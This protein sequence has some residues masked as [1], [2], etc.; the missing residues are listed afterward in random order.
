M[1]SQFVKKTRRKSSLALRLRGDLCFFAKAFSLFFSLLA[2]FLTAPSVV[3]APIPVDS[4]RGIAHGVAS[5][6]QVSTSSGAAI[7]LA[8]AVAPME[9]KVAAISPTNSNAIAYY[10]V[11]RGAVGG[12]VVMSAD[13]RLDPVLVIAP[14]GRFDATPG[15][16]LYDI[17]SGDVQRRIAV[18]DAGGLARSKGWSALLE[19]SRSVDELGAGVA[20]IDDV[21]VDPLVQS[22]W[23]QATVGGK[24]VYNYYTPNHYVCGCVATAGS[25]IMRYHKYPRGS[26]APVTREC[27]VGGYST[28]ETMIGG[29]YEWDKM[30]LVPNSSITDEQCQAIG[31]LCYDLGVS[32]YMS[33]ANGSSGTGGYCL[34]EAFLSVFGY[35]N[36]MTYQLRSGSLSGTDI[37]NALLSN[38]DAECPV[39][40]GIDGSHGGHSIVGDGYGYSN[41]RLYVHLNLGWGGSDDAWYNLP[42]IGTSFSFNTVD[43]VVYNIFPEDSCDLLTGRVLDAATGEPIA[44]ATVQAMAGQGGTVAGTVK[45]SP[46]GIYALRLEGGQSYSVVASAPGAEPSEMSVFLPRSVTTRTETRYYY[47][48]TGSI[49]N[50]WGN[51]FSLS[52]A[53]PGPVAPEAPTGVSAADGTS[54]AKVRITWNASSGA[55]YYRVYRG[56]SNSASAATVLAAS[57]TTSYY[58]DNT[59]EVGTHY[60]YWVKAGNSSGESALS[61]S[62]VG[63]RAFS[64]PAAPTGVVASDGTSTE[65]VLVTWSSVAAAE[66]YSV[67]RS[68][69]SSSSSAVMIASGLTSTSYTDTSAVAGTVY[70]YWV[71]ST[72]PGGTSDFSTSDDGYRKPSAPS[73]PAGVSAS[74]GLSTTVIVISWNAVNSAASYSV[75]RSTS[76]SSSSA[77]QIASALTATTYSDTTAAS[78]VTYYYWVR[79][80]NAGGTSAFSS[81]DVGYLAVIVG[82]ESVA[83]SDGTMANYVKVSWSASANAVKYEVWRGTVNDYSQAS[84]LSSP[85]TTS[86]NDTSVQPGMRYYYWVRAVTVAGTSAFSSSDTGYRPL[87]V[88]TNVRATTGNSTGVTVSWSAVSGAVSYEISRGE[89]GASASSATVIGTTTALSYMDASAVPG[90]TYAYFVRARASACNSAWSSAALGSRSVPTPTGLTAS[91]GLYSGHVLVNWPAMP[92]AESYELMRSP[93]DNIGFAETIATTTDTSFRDATVEYGL[94]YYYFLRAKFSAGMSPWSSSEA[95]WR[96]FPVPTGIAADDGTSTANVKIVWD[97]V[98]GATLFQVWRYSNARS[99]NELIGTSTTTSYSDN[100]GIEPGTKYSYRIKAVFPTG[101]S[102]LS[103]SDTGYLKAS[104]PAVVASDGTSTDR[105]TLTWGAAAGAVAY[106]VYR[107]TTSSSANAELLDSTS[108][109]FY[110]DKT[111]SR[112]GLYYYWVRTATGLDTSDFGTSDTGYAGLA[113][114][115]RVTASDGAYADKVVVSWGAVSGAQ[116]YEV[117]RGT[118]DDYQGSSRVANGVSGLAWEDV[119]ATPGMKCWYWVRAC[120][121]SAVPGLW[122]VNDSG[123]RKFSAPTDVTAST[124]QTDGIKVSWKGTTTGVSFEIY[125][126]MSDDFSQAAVVATVSGASN[127]TDNSTVPGYVYYYWVRAYSDLSESSWSDSAHG[128]RVISAPA[129][130]SATDGMSLDNV[131]VTWSAATSAKYYEIWRATTTK[132]DDAELIGATTNRLVWVDSEVQS[133]VLYYYWVKAVSVLDTSAFSNRDSGYAST[134][135]PAGVT[136]SDGLA[137]NYVRVAWTAADGALSY[138]VWRAESEDE[139]SATQLKSGITEPTCDD[140]TVV[141]G[142]FYW[143]WVRPVSTAGQGVFAGPDRGFARLSAPTGVTA[144]TNNTGKVIVSWTKSTGATSYEIFRAE[145]NDVAFATNAV[146]ASVTTTTCNDTNA[147]PAVKYW[148]WVRA[149]AEADVSPLGGPADGFQLLVAPT[150]VAAS[151]GTSDEFVKVTWSEA[152]GASS[153]E[154]WRAE[155]STKTTDATLLAGVTNALEYLDVS[156]APGVSY[157]YWLKAVSTYITTGLSVSDKGWRSLPAPQTVS[158]SDG[159]IPEGVVVEWSPVENAVKYEVWRNGGDEATTNGATRVFTSV[160]ATTCVCTNTSATP[161]VR[162]WFWVRSVS[163][164]GTGVFSVPDDGFRAVATPTNLKA[165]D[166]SSYDYVR[167]TWGAVTGAEAYEVMRVETNELYA[168]ETNVIRVTGTTFDDTNAVPGIVYGYCVRTLSPLSTS[169]YARPDTGFRKLQKVTDLVAGDGVSGEGVPLSWTVP[170]GARACQIWRGTSTSSSSATRLALLPAEESTYLDATA[171]AGVKYYYW[172]GGVA[173]VEGELGTSNDGWRALPVPE[174]VEATDGDSTAHVRITWITVPDATKYEIWRG[175]SADPNAMT[176]VKSFS[177]APAEMAW[178][179]TGAS[180]GVLYYYTVRAGG[181]GG[182]G[183]FATPESGYRA[184]MPP[185]SVAATDGTLAGKVTVS[186]RAVTGATHYQVYRADGAEAPKQAWSGWQTA[187][188]FTDVSCTGAT[189]YWYFVVAATDAQGTRPSAFSAGDQG[190]AKDDGTGV[191]PVNLGGG[192]TWPVVAGSN[193]TA[194]TN[195][196]SFTS[197]EGGR[198]TFPG[199]QGA[200]G[201][202]TTVQVLVKT[203]LDD[204]ATYTVEGVL[205]IISAGTAELDLHEVW[206]SRPSLFVIGITTEKGAPLP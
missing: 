180:V 187:T 12:F 104:S 124:N 181:T 125:R 112:G 13:D 194:T 161:G 94:T 126:G 4:V 27:Y 48:D 148:Y 122:G 58:D 166:G 184:L 120:G 178:E 182:W 86:Y 155:N 30:P 8:Q 100:K 165:A 89:S 21:R 85:T 200:V 77:T 177:S 60:Y 65:G 90:V 53:A 115:S 55:T 14:T 188:S 162:Y 144:T 93:E 131:T 196:V 108:M 150:V 183:A 33:W 137:T 192:I 17:L 170:V 117:W 68:E 20:S 164:T 159:T 18:A 173:D 24:N 38:F 80:T 63:W 189:R 2:L 81:P 67:W 56:V 152:A 45:T 62:D 61:A 145:T 205:K 40:L 140:A 201:A 96:A 82:P 35:R 44:G 185:S 142:K 105:V 16:P 190:Y 71:K 127:Y 175:T 46:K 25:Q 119:G 138:N 151:D 130:I 154:V 146:F 7:H 141:P 160:D 26:V 36:A 158:A 88:P 39:E 64:K 57:V 10:V 167:V 99:R 52:M 202:T 172:V 171:L 195:A 83:A 116:T 113:A 103:E 6:V 50:S 168:V 132:T 110:E 176:S 76:S 28:Y 186:W 136:A 72:N 193:G 92:G 42:N 37:E 95:G 22:K 47:P 203:A 111:A 41:G 79:A 54:T 59:A 101:T 23:N 206:G 149:C 198:L 156:A 134:P 123:W 43:N 66:S 32:I 191:T 15:T 174:P 107:S 147:L 204:D 133:G 49:G 19:G 179:D 139:A 106:L 31:K 153:Y 91:D 84:K 121:S 102:M 69:Y 75:W 143:Y 109:L 51:D 114:V 70:Y 197:V 29:V 98:E 5:S 163:A 118:T 11:D 78:G 169:A 87:G 135:A 9:V 74:D 128:S 199:V 1:E 73:A 129:T 97:A 34:K 3:A 157:T